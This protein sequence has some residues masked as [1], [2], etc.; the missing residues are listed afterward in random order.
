MKYNLKEKK[1]EDEKFKRFY[2]EYPLLINK[3]INDDLNFLGDIF[4]K[5]SLINSIY[6][7]IKLIDINFKLNPILLIEGQEGQLNFI[8]KYLIINSVNSF[9]F[10]IKKQMYQ[11]EEKDMDLELVNIML[12]E[13]NNFNYN[14]SFNNNQLI[15]K[16]HITISEENQNI[17]II[18]NFL[19]YLYDI[20]CILLNNL[21]SS[22]VDHFRDEDII[23]K[24][25]SNIESCFNFF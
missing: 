20:L 3:Y 5:D 10:L 23:E 1:P 15:N 6:L 22:H 12:N 14:S 21:L 8:L 16:K 13:E 2:E 7:P 17:I 4:K 19:Y 11:Y 18:S 9:N 25:L 24:L